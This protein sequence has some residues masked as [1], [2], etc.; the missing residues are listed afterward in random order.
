MDIKKKLK[1]YLENIIFKSIRIVAILLLL[2]SCLS[3]SLD[4]TN[5]GYIIN[6]TEDTL[7]CTIFGNTNLIPSSVDYIAPH[8]K[9]SLGNGQYTQFEFLYKIK[10]FGDSVNVYID[11]NKDSCV[12]VW[13]PP[14]QRL[15]DSIHSFYNKQSWKI[16][17]GGYKDKY[18]V[19]TFTIRE[20]DIK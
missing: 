6:D 8:Q 19:A 3:R 9:A 4:A 17:K 10:N 14:L 2:N 11:K 13:Y 16:S 12:C 15:P 20:E 5:Q 18:T 1:K 7:Y